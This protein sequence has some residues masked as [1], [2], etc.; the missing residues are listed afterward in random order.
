MLRFIK[1]TS[2][3][4]YFIVSVI[5]VS[6][7]FQISVKWQ[8]IESKCFYWTLRRIITGLFTDK[9]VFRLEFHSEL[10]TDEKP[11]FI[12]SFKLSIYTKC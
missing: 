12:F 11:W 5:F 4:Q 8:M 6:Q 2:Q 1:F 7:R 10:F 9:I 3:Y